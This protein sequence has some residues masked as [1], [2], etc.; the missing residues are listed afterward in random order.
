MGRVSSSYGY[1]LAERPFCC[2]G[3][4]GLAVLAALA[5]Y[6]CECPWIVIPPKSS[7][8][9]LPVQAGIQEKQRG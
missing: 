3:P 4:P 6:P 2:L 7:V 5:W 1:I 9:C 8:D